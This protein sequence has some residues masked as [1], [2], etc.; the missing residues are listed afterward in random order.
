M[1]EREAR[2]FGL[3]KLIAKTFSANM[4]EQAVAGSNF[5]R[6]MAVDFAHIFFLAAGENGFRGHI[7][8]PVEPGT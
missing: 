6:R 4:A 7:S 3:F 8:F 1:L 5:A 2:R